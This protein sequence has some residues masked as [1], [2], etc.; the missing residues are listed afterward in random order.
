MLVDSPDGGFREIGSEPLARRFNFLELL[1]A[2][3]GAHTPPPPEPGPGGDRQQRKST[4]SDDICEILCDAVNI[5]SG[6]TVK[7]SADDRPGCETA[8]KTRT[9]PNPRVHPKI[10]QG[11]QK[12]RGGVRPSSRNSR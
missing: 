7:E 12:Y 2:Q 3:L 11:I 4:G 9:A 6:Q 8:P 1:I 10:A 5:V